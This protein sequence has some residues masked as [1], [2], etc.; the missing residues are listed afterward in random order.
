MMQEDT[1]T[2]RCPT[3]SS[4]EV[5]ITADWSHLLDEAAPLTVLRPNPPKRN[6]NAK[7]LQ[8][9]PLLSPEECTRLNTAAERIGF[10]RTAY[11]QHYRGNLRLI[12]TDQG[13]ADKLWERVRRF[14]PSRVRGLDVDGVP[15]EWEACGLNE[16]FRLAKYR[17]GHR[18]GAHCDAAFVRNEDEMSIYTLN[19]YTNTVHPEHGGRT[20]F[21][22]DGARGIGDKD[23]DLAVRPEE[24]LCVAFMQPPQAELKH[25]GEELTAGV[26]YLLRSD[27]MYRRVEPASPGA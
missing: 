25:D 7:L 11:P 21:Y 19:V 20:R 14:V 27:V 9:D 22:A 12:V 24:G 13:L 26:K 15:S 23:V 16:V 2:K 5:R 18:F 1:T 10:G 6:Y 8:L 17:P 4:P 3:E